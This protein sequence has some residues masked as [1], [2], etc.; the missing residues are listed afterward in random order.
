[1]RRPDVT[2]RARRVRAAGR[3]A[4]RTDV[5]VVLRHVWQEVRD[6]DVPMLAAGVAFYSFLAVFPG[7][8]AALLVY[9]L[10]ADPDDVE[11]QV[12][13]LSDVLPGNARAVVLDVLSSVADGS[14]PALGLGLAVSLVVALWSASTGVAGM[15]KAVNVAYDT[16]KRRGFA[17][18]RGLALLLT[19]GAVFFAVLAVGLVAVLPAVLNAT[20][21]LSSSETWLRAARWVLLPVAFASAVGVLYR[22]APVTRPSGLR[23]LSLG[24]VVATV[25]WLAASFGFSA[26]VDNLGTYGRTYGGVAGVAV[27]LL[28]LFATAFSVLL[29]AELDAETRRHVRRRGTAEG[30]ERAAAGNGDDGARPEHVQ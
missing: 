25:L 11:R 20:P 1:V 6:D 28:W 4:A 26:Y 18:R 13:S 27:L 10:V 23:W 22:V 15:M 30:Q 5:G 3:R 21:G 9:G 7:L 14:E 12:T 29:G 19:L 24:S 16:E 8:V 2:T 17:A